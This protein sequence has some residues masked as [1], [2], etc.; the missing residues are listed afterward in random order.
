VLGRGS[1]SGSALA[2]PGADPGRSTSRIGARPAAPSSGNGAVGSS[3]GRG[4]TSC[5]T[6]DGCGLEGGLAC[7]PH[8]GT[9]A[10][11]RT[12]TADQA[13]DAT[14]SGWRSGVGRPPRPGPPGRPPGPGSGE[15]GWLPLGERSRTA[16]PHERVEVWSPA[17]KAGGG[18][19]HWRRPSVGSSTD[20]RQCTRWCGR[21]ASLPPARAGHGER[22]ARRG[23]DVRVVGAPEV[24]SWSDTSTNRRTGTSV[25]GGCGLRS[26]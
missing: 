20:G 26:A 13:A 9:V 10:R 21:T 11:S 1:S 14:G 2:R 3:R 24:H 6:G 18:T 19:A 22:G 25:P 17:A 4:R 12:A 15:R 5:A 7:A 16:R 23:T 8:G